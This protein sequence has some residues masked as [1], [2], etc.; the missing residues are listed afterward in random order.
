MIPRTDQRLPGN[1]IHSSARRAV[2]DKRSLQGTTQPLSIATAA[3]GHA[4]IFT[5][6]EAAKHV[7]LGIQTEHFTPQGTK[8]VTA[9]DGAGPRVSHTAVLFG[10]RIVTSIDG[11]GPWWDAEKYHPMYLFTNPN[12]YQYPTHRLHW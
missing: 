12:G 8:I 9:I 6:A 10:T 5:K 4:T 3:A 11:A 1:S 2:G 7:T